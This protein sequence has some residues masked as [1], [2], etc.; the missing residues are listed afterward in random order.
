MTLKDTYLCDKCGVSESVKPEGNPSEG[1][2]VVQW[3]LVSQSRMA[4]LPLAHLCGECFPKIMVQLG[5]GEDT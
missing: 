3:W 5:R 1:W 4:D 2:R